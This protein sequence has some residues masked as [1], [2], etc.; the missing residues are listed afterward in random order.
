MALAVVVAALVAM[1]IY[2]KRAF[3][4]S[5]KSAADNLGPQYDLRQTTT[6]T[7]TVRE[8]FRDAVTRSVVVSEVDLFNLGQSGECLFVNGA[9]CD[10]CPEATIEACDLDRDNDCDSD[11]VFATLS[12]TCLNR[13]TSSVRSNE[14]V[15]APPS[16]PSLW[17][18]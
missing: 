4:G 3:S 6:N 18:R 10:I 5:L 15:A 16:T 11:R 8:T 1:Q 14:T 7:P 9:E 12:S 17:S 13:E 2:V